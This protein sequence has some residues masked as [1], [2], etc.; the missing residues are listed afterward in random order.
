MISI[1]TALAPV[2]LE[3]YQLRRYLGRLVHSP[4]A[5]AAPDETLRSQVVAEA[6]KLD[7]PVRADDVKI[8]HSS[9]QVEVQIKYAVQMDFPLYQ[10]DLHFHPNASSR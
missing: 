5:A 4:K 6:H 2:Y 10:V 8:T 3:D 7:L 1:L 9:D